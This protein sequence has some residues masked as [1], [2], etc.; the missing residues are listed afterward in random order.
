MQSIR[1]IIEGW[2]AGRFPQT[3]D[4]EL[5]TIYKKHGSDKKGEGDNTHNYTNLYYPIF[6]PL[7]NQT[8]NFFE[9][10]L[11]SQNTSIPWHFNHGGHKMGASVYAAEEFFPSAS[12]YGADIDSEIR[13]NPGRIKTFTCD[14]KNATTIR[15]MWDGPELKDKKFE[16]I[17]EDACHEFDANYCFAVNSLHKLAPQG[18]FI[19]EDVWVGV[20]NKWK[21]LQPTMMA[22]FNL[23]LFEILPGRM[24]TIYLIIMQL[25]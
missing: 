19:I 7:R 12:I 20:L 11:G 4:T 9:L 17:L 25:K 21:E 15:A 8:F 5:C 3:E 22:D 2:K 13:L 18:V 14:A 24:Q 23:D 1:P 10:G 16:I 6:L